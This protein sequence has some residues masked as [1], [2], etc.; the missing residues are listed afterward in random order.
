MIIH[1]KDD[2]RRTIE[3]TLYI[4][5]D[6]MINPPSASQIQCWKDSVLTFF[7]LKATATKIDDLDGTFH[8]VFEKDILEK[9]GRVNVKA[10][11]ELRTPTSGFKSQWTIR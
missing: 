9:S 1:S 11:R 3:S 10:N 6:F 7:M 8:R 5:V 4:G 2:F